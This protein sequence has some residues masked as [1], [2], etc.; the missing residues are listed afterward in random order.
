MIVKTSKYF[1]QKQEPNTNFNQPD[2]KMFSKATSSISQHKFNGDVENEN[3]LL[4][5]I[6]R[7]GLDLKSEVS[8]RD[9]IDKNGTEGIE[10]I[11]LVYWKK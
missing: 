5:T 6:N 4:Q 9:Y 3:E 7:E 2:N 10:G 11:W 8:V 1:I